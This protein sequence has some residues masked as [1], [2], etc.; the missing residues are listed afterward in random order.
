MEVVVTSTILPEPIT[1]SYM[2]AYLETYGTHHIINSAHEHV[3]PP[4]YVY[5][6]QLQ[7]Q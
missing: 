2:L 5:K 6:L 4:L 1:L 3:Q 7:T